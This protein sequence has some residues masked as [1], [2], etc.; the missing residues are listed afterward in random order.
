MSDVKAQ[1][2]QCSI[3]VPLNGCLT[4][5]IHRHSRIELKLSGCMGVKSI[6]TAV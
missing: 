2:A 1:V 4:G 5:K 3:Y 6:A